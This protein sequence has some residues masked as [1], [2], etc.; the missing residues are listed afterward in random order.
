MNGVLLPGVKLAGDA[1]HTLGGALVPPA[2]LKV[3]ELVYPLMAVMLPLKA[4]FWPTNAD[5]GVFVM[6]KE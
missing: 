3:T 2:Q 4:A 6:K 1:L 5:S